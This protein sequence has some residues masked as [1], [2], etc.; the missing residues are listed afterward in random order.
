MI[1]RPARAF[2]GRSFCFARSMKAFLVS[3]F[4]KTLLLV[5]FAFVALPIALA[6]QTIAVTVSG[7][8]PNSWNVGSFGP[9]DI[10]LPGTNF[11]NSTQPV[12]AGKQVDID[13]TG[14]PGAAEVTIGITKPVDELTTWNGT[15]TLWI[16]R[17][18]D[19]TGTGSIT[20]LSTDWVPILSTGYTDI[21][22][23]K[24]N[25][26]NVTV[27]LQ[28]RNLVVAAGTTSSS[29]S[30]QTTLTYRAIK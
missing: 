11:T 14:F 26:L 19:G 8:D 23:V 28:M 20:W 25:R 15:Y 24:R 13:I 17:V 10:G 16:R 3:C 6:A 1:E 29:P 12:G 30:F 5:I 22:S 2:L 18:D 9:A 21:F 4:P 7:A 27:E